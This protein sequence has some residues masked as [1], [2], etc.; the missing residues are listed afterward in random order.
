[1]DAIITLRKQETCQIIVRNVPHD[2]R[3]P[4]SEWLELAMS[5][6][7]KDWEED[8]I[9]VDSFE[10]VNPGTDGMAEVDFRPLKVAKTCLDCE[11]EVQGNDELCG[12]CHDERD[13]IEESEKTIG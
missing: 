12:E 13:R 4:L 11:Q 5:A 9:E 1:M 3:R 8:D 2:H 6:R 7:G 10:I